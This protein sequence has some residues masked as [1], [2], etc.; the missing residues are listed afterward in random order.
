MIRGVRRESWSKSGWRLWAAALLVVILCLAFACSDSAG[1][2]TPA[3]ILDTDLSSDV[4]DAGAVAVLH[5]L[6]DRGE[7][8]ILAMMISSGDPWSGPCLDALNTSFGRPDIPIGVINPA[9]VIDESKYTAYMANH[10]DHDFSLANNGEDA[11][12]LYRKV[13][14]QQPDNSVSIVTIGYLSNL[15]RLLN[16]GPDQYSPLDGL[17]LVKTKVKRLVCM[18]G[19]FPKGREWNFY[20]DAR[21]TVATMQRWPTPITFVG[22]EIGSRVKTGKALREVSETQPLRVAYQRYNQTS[23]RESW[24]QVAVLVAVH[25]EKSRPKYWSLAKPGRVVVEEDGSNTWQ[26]EAKGQGR[27]L[28]W[29]EHSDQLAPMIDLLMVEAAGSAR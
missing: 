27:Y 5:A 4:D 25:P 8:D 19:K 3:I 28:L 7:A 29:H 9:E 11:F 24:D 18:G 12:L 2:D 17:A 22:F 26:S 21:A 6:A 1:P 13:L 10:F 14:A 20:R 16:S 23:N 15:A